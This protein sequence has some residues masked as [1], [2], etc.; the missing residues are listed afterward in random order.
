M[1]QDVNTKKEKDEV[2]EFRWLTKINRV[3]GG[4]FQQQG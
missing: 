4:I 2:G 1:L 3:R